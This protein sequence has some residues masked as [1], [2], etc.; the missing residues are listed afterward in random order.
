MAL[1]KLMEEAERLLRSAGVDEPRL[2]LSRDPRYGE[3]SS[4]AAFDLAKKHKRSPNEV[5]SEIVDRM[6]SKEMELIKDVEAVRGYINFKPDWIRYSEEILR[7]ILEK[8]ESCLL[9]TS[10]SP[11]DRG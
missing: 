3:V 2:E 1:R 8:G 5:A 9:Y 7:E 4:L 11:R 10:P 6:R